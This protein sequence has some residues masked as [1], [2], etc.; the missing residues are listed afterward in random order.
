V[1]VTDGNYVHMVYV[2]I[3]TFLEDGNT[4]DKCHIELKIL[5]LFGLHTY[6]QSASI[7]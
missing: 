6:R 7:I 1:A 3:L 4:A 5:G 2:R